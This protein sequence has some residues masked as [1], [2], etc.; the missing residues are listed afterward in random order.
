M[1]EQERRHLRLQYA[2]GRLS[3]FFIAGPAFLIL[4]LL[5]YRIENLKEIRE[6]VRKAT[7]KQRGG[8]IICANHLTMIDSVIIAW[9]LMP[10]SRYVLDYRF[11][12]W[13]LPERENFDRNI[14]LSMICYLTKCIPIHRGGSREEIKLTMDKCVYLLERDSNIVIFPEGGRSRTGTINGETVSYGV[15]RMAQKAPLSRILCVY[16]RGLG[17]K[18]YS[19]I[20]RRGERFVVKA[21]V[22]DPFVTERG[23]K[24]QRAIAHRIVEKLA[25]ME[26]EWFIMTSGREQNVSTSLPGSGRPDSLTGDGGKVLRGTLPVLSD[27]KEK[28]INRTATG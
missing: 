8:W 9:A 12:P 20:P 19:N 6:S 17:Q 22:F 1:N 2:L 21:E 3:V 23:L 26:R 27:N 16:L 4:K 15:G 18:N 10:F 7:E 5:G 14:M 11:L 28:T 24:G 13:N 25:I